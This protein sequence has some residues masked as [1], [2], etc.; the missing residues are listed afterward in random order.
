MDSNLKSKID[1]FIQNR[2]AVGDAF[3]FEYGLKCN[4]SRLKHF[5]NVNV[6]SGR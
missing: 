1:L 4:M 6:K 5:Q 2:Q 3:I